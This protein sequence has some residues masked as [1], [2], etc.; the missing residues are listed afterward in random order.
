MES[1]VFLIE[2]SAMGHLLRFQW[3]WNKKR[4]PWT[5]L[6]AQ[7]TVFSICFVHIT[8]YTISWLAQGPGNIL[9]L[10]WSLF[11]NCLY[12]FLSDLSLMNL[13]LSWLYDLLSTTLLPVPLFLSFPQTAYLAGICLIPLSLPL[14]LWESSRLG[15]LKHLR[16]WFVLLSPFG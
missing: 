6:N 11:I 8:M 12:N 16:T 14:V 7:S 3:C 2:D 10:F 1:F 15:S 4:L 13:S 5:L 9:P